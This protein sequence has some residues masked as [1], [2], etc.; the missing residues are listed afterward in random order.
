[1]YGPWPVD[2]SDPLA[3]VLGSIMLSRR[4]RLHSADG[5][6]IVQKVSTHEEGVPDYLGQERV[7][8]LMKRHAGSRPV[9]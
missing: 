6:F 2:A 4:P 9:T 3:T 1:M 5:P 8:Q 7:I